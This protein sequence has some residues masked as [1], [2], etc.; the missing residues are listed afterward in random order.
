M[1]A[2]GWWITIHFFPFI[3]LDSWLE[4]STRWRSEGYK[5]QK[6]N[7]INMIDDDVMVIMI[8]TMMIRGTHIEILILPLV[9]IGEGNGN[10]LQYS[11]LENPRDKGAWWAAVYGVTQS[12][13]RLKW[14]SSIPSNHLDIILTGEDPGHQFSSVQFSHSVMSDPGHTSC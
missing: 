8:G 12:Q 7:A 6:V 13:T 4:G 1:H 2:D 5:W 14:L 10:P 3:F 9:I 11:C